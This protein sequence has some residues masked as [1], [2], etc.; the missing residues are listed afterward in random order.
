MAS[1]SSALPI[2]ATPQRPWRSAEDV[3]FATLEWVDWFNLR[4]LLGSIGHMPPAEF[5]AMYYPTQHGSTTEVGLDQSRLREN[6][7]EFT[8]DRGGFS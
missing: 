2:S 4:R 8:V 1:R 3:E 7:G 5:E 6:P